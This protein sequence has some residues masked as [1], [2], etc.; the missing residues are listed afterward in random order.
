MTVLEGYRIAVRAARPAARLAVTTNAE[1][2]RMYQIL[3]GTDEL[4]R[5]EPSPSIAWKEADYRLANPHN[6]AAWA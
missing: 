5:V 3:D 6:A 1:G 2:V 4:S